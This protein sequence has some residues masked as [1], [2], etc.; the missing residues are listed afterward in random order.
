M[1]QNN[2]ASVRQILDKT[3]TIHDQ[4]SE[5]LNDP[6]ITEEKVFEIKDAI[7]GNML[8]SYFTLLHYL[9]DKEY[10]NKPMIVIP[11]MN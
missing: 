2:P 3:I 6:E 10:A 9:A 1:S 5:Q 4:L 11:G 8:G 7:I